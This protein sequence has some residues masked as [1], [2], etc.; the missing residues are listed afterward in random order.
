MT[1]NR[2]KLDST[3]NGH[4]LKLQERFLMDRTD[5]EAEIHFV[6]LINQSVKSFFPQIV[7]VFHKWAVAMR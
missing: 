6:N 4:E 1:K 7:E 2:E 3:I 5:Q